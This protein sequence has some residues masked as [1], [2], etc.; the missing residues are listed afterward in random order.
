MTR[1][2]VALSPVKVAPNV[3]AAIAGFRAVPAHAKWDTPDDVGGCYDSA[4]AFARILRSAGVPYTFRR[5]NAPPGW[6]TEVQHVIEV[7]GVV[8]DWIAR[9]FRPGCEWPH[10][11]T[12]GAFELEFGSPLPCCADCG[13]SRGPLYLVGKRLHTRSL[14]DHKC[15]GPAADPMADVVPILE[16]LWKR[17]T[18]REREQFEQQLRAGLRP[19]ATP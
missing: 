18:P 12:V 13:A 10:V 14:S 2:S 17:L 3:A 15:K 11:M 8:V 9:Q 7:D 4:L 5:Y 1:D 19:S 6:R 16:T